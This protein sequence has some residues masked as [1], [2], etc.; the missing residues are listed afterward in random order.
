MSESISKRNKR[1]WRVFGI[2]IAALL[3]Y[4]LYRL[5]GYIDVILYGI[6]VY[7]VTRPIYERVNKK[8][9]KKNI[10][11]G[12]SL[13]LFVLPVILIFIYASIVAAVELNSLLGSIDYEIP[14]E[15]FEET[16]DQ[17]NVIGK[18]LTSRDNETCSIPTCFDGIQNQ[19]ETGID[20]GGTCQPCHCKNEILDENETEIDC[21]GTCQPCHCKN[22][23]LD[24]NET[25]IDCGGS[26]LP[27]GNEESCLVDG[28]CT[29]G[30]CH[31]GTCQTPSCDSEQLIPQEDHTQV[32]QEKKNLTPSELW[33][34]ITD[35]LN[36]SE[37]IGP[38]TDIINNVVNLIVMFAFKLFL[39]F[40]IGF[41]LLKDGHQL[42]EWFPK[43]ALGGDTELFERFIE[44]VDKDLQK[45][46]FGNILVAVLTACIAIVLF[47]ILNFIAP[48]LS[49]GL[50]LEIPYPF[51][52]GLLC[53]IGIF[54]PGIGI[55]IVWVPLWMY[56]A[57]QAYLHN[58]LLG[59]GWFLL[60]FPVTVFLLVDLAPDLILRPIISSR[61]IHRGV[62]LLAYLFGYIAFGF[63][64]LFLGP[65]IIVLA[66]NFISI[67]LPE[68]RG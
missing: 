25:E 38:I 2:L 32:T 4:M 16:I 21:G 8:L 61:R 3:L 52:L 29:T 41:Y 63:M 40:T 58:M 27:C 37:F 30:L 39:M 59:A 57:I 23:I 64:G 50:K 68:I 28:D 62:L 26:C 15:S 53:G 54:V 65:I 56:L 42:R 31:E 60:L 43:S 20:C 55:K 11:A 19:D 6:F 34:M 18:E 13:F 24:E 33:T 5:G 17:L 7:Y 22:E 67:V 45:I 35:R 1:Y 49:P 12:L 36:L 9:N 66:T 46:F 51:L 14:V 10:S 44:S 48:G 47:H